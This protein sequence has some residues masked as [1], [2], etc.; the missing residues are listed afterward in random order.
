MNSPGSTR[1]LSRAGAVQVPGAGLLAEIAA[2]LA[3]GEDLRDLLRR[4]L[5]PIVRLAGAQAG[6]VRTLS[7]DGLSLELMGDIGLPSQVCGSERTVERH[8]GHCG[9]AAEA[10]QVVWATDLS[11]CSARSTSNYFG[12]ECLRMLDVPLQRRGRLLGVYNLFFHH[13]VEPS[14]EVQGM[15][16]SVGEI[17]GLALENARLENEKL[18]NAVVNE[19]Q[20]LAAEV[21]DSIAQVLVFAKMRMP[22]LQEA[23]AS[24]DEER[25]S[26]YCAD[27]RQAVSEAHTSLRQILTHFRTTMDP[28]GLVH[29]VQNAGQRLQIRSGV[30]FELVNDVPGLRL[31]PEQES[32]AF[33]IV[34]EALANVA[35]H[36]LAHH[37]WVTLRQQGECVEILVE[38][39]GAGLHSDAGSGSDAHLGLG[40]MADR[41]RRLGGE[42]CIADRAG[43][44]TSIRLRFP[45]AITG[46]GPS[47]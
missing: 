31:A 32:Q 46:R 43:G 28:L 38:D 16:K 2:D 36:A 9:E 47:A 12:T 18:R 14:P 4:F 39:D 41:A 29:A 19:R 23:I 6:A 3:S 27:V 10:R 34:Q 22:L 30:D 24:H 44:G 8:C 17:L 25:S 20:M 40:I 26:K 5:E 33:H 37:A 45:V 11:V 42:L 1:E 7:Q 13:A 15:L 35:K 21:H